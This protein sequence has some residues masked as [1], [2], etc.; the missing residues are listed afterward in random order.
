MMTKPAQVAGF[1]ENGQGDD[2][3]DAGDLLEG[4]EVRGSAQKGFNCLWSIS[5]IIRG[6][7]V[8]PVIFM[9]SSKTTFG[10]KSSANL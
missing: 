7:C 10:N 2:R 5:Q 9:P 4:L 6:R 1:S 8:T 3:A